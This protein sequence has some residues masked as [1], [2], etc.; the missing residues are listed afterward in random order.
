MKLTLRTALI[1]SLLVWHNLFGD[2]CFPDEFLAEL[3]DGESEKVE[4]TYVDYSDCHYCENEGWGGHCQ[5]EEERPLTKVL[6]ADSIDGFRVLELTYENQLKDNVDTCVPAGKY[7]Y[8]ILDFDTYTDSRPGECDSDCEKEGDPIGTEANFLKLKSPAT[9]LTVLKPAENFQYQRN[10]LKIL[11]I[12]L[13]LTM[14]TIPMKLL[15]LTMKN[16]ILTT[17]LTTTTMKYPMKMI[18]KY[19]IPVMKHRTITIIM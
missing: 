3:V 14:I 19:R 9:L 2:T 6:R 5:S 1:F 10:S 11:N 13:E 7:T 18:R 16:L 8:L 12:N 4:L 15:I 17:R